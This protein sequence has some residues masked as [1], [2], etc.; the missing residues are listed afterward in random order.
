MKN[1]QEILSNPSGTRM[2]ISQN[3]FVH[4]GN[5]YFRI[6]R[7]IGMEIDQHAQEMEQLGNTF[8]K[9]SEIDDMILIEGPLVCPSVPTGFIQIMTDEGNTMV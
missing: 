7:E 2:A 5:Y 4:I 9:I 3:N 8:H 1:K 6:F